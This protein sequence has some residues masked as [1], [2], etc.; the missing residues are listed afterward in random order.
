MRRSRGWLIG[1][2]I[3][4]LCV[5]V[6]IVVL[7]VPHGHQAG[8]A[9]EPRPTSS[10][11]ADSAAAQAQQVANALKKLTTNP[12]SLVAA[13]AQADVGGRAAQALPAGSK[14][15]PDPK[16]WEPDGLGGGVMTVSVTSPGS[17][18][19]DY[20]AVMVN[21]GGAWKVL[22]TWKLSDQSQAPTAAAS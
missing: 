4:T 12:A 5:T 19:V 10:G 20:A 18:P 13:G 7:L 21:E 11:K 2:I 17:P 9:G 6:V 3:A 16:S 15:T 8:S 1:A 22:A 14:V